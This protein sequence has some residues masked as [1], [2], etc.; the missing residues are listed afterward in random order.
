MLA[1]IALGSN[2]EKAARC[3]RHYERKRELQDL[4]VRHS[5]TEEEVPG[6]QLTRALTALLPQS[7]CAI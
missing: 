3:E 5:E 4:S 7:L 2:S 6:F 1:D